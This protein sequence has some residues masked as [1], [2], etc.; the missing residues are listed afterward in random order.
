[1]QRLSNESVLNHCTTTL[2]LFCHNLILFN[3][4]VLTP[5]KLQITKYLVKFLFLKNVITPFKSHTIGAH[6]TIRLDPKQRLL[7]YNLI[8]L[9][10]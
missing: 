4:L 1:M 6:K 9:L 10:Y 5:F 8:Y 2:I 7:T 3:L